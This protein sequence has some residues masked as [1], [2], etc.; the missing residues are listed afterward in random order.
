MNSTRSMKI[1][2]LLQKWPR[3]TV[4][5]HVWL[6]KQGISWKLAEQ[7]RKRGWIDAL[8]RGAFV[9]RGDTVTWQGGI[10]ALQTYSSSTIHPGGRTAL[11][12]QGLAHFLPLGKQ[13]IHLYG[14]AGERLPAWFRE[15]DW[16]ANIHFTV[17]ALFTGAENAGLTKLQFGDSHILASS[18]ER[19][20]LEYLDDVPYPNSFD[21]ALL[22]M[23][24][25]ATLRPALLHRLLEACSSVK[26]KRVFLFLADH[27][28]H[29]WNRRVDRDGIDLGRGKRVVVR[30]GRL[31]AT[32]EITVP[33]H[34]VRGAT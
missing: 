12:L 17:R 31:D 30:G 33:S 13:S 29:R 26:V 2:Q 5:L 22:L 23:E 4:A 8:G 28:G 15:H 10:Y 14:S 27:V 1:N 19:A 24:G 25:L 20:I 6:S 34:F 7:Y 18:P 21:E 11:E 3:G 32:Y 9:R 16:S